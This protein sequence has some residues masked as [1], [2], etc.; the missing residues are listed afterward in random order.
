MASPVQPLHAPSLKEACV[1]RLEALILSGEFQIGERLP[2][3]RELAGRLGISRPVLH[4][5][6]VDLAAKGLVRVV[7]RHSVTVNDFRTHGSVAILSSLLAYQQGRLDSTMAR[8]LMDMRILLET[9]TARLAARYYTAEQLARLRELLAQEEATDS[10]DAASLTELDF[11]FHLQVA[12]ASGNLVYPL[13]INSFKA[14]YTNLT[15][16]FFEKYCGTPVIAEVLRFHGRLVQA[17][18]ARDTGEAGMVMGE[19]LRHGEEL[20]KGAR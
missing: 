20:L 2:P 1:A 6:L 9:E 3:E 7:P 16:L 11:S 4:E 13:I 14:V 19:T 8:S 17:I 18:A 12:L 5:A 10:R 15:H